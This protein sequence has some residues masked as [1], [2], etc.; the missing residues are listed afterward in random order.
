MFAPLGGGG[1][2]GAQSPG[3]SSVP[4]LLAAAPPLAPLSP[5]SLPHLAGRGSP[6]KGEHMCVVIPILAHV[7]TIH[8]GIRRPRRVPGYGGGG[9]GVG[10]VG[11]G[12]QRQRAGRTMTRGSCQS[13]QTKANE[14]T[15]VVG[16]LA[17]VGQ[18][19]QR[20]KA[21]RTMTR[22]SCQ[23]R[24]TKANETTRVVGFLACVDLFR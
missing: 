22:G 12:I 2:G 15:R 9:V 1:R 21:G 20:Q 3:P 4:P 7:F 24:W 23:S 8:G 19:K 14:T 10:V 16:F 17:C 18:G 6:N 5:F 11:Q 13:R